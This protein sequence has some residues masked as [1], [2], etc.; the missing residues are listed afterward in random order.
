MFEAARRNSRE[1]I[2]LRRSIRVI[3]NPVSGRRRRADFVTRL[4][5]GWR[6]AGADVRVSHTAGP[7]DARCLAA[8]L[9][10]E[11]ELLAVVGGD[12]TVNEA[13]AGLNR[14]R[15]P[16]LVVP[17]GTENL[18]AEYLQM[19]R[20]AER[21]VVSGLNG[22]AVNFD[23]GLAG[24][25][26]FHSV[27]GVGFDAQVVREFVRRRRGHVSHWSYIVPLGRTFRSWHWPRLSVEIDGRPAFDGPGLVF[28]GNTP[29][30]ALGLRILREARPDDG[31]LDVCVYPCA[32]RSRLLWWSA[33][34]LFRGHVGRRGLLY[35]RATRLRVSSDRPVPVE[36]DGEP[37]GTTPVE[38]E[39]LPAVAQLIAA[40]RP[41]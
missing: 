38:Y 25:R 18:L 39:V 27:S 20:T 5:A 22:A 36:I 10:A 33:W 31:L 40:P 15:L 19:P 4:V 32:S 26:P 28:V 9:P 3:V 13:L 37:H 24:G 29:R 2:F 34:T 14:R 21:L 1:R 30:Y 12:G 35:R 11:T 41:Q 17:G 16:L 6:S 8:D 7:G 23:L